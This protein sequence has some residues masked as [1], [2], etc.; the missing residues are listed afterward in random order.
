MSIYYKYTSDG[1]KLVVLSDV[2][3]S[4]YWYKSEELGKWF[5]D[6]LVKIPYEIPRI[7]T[8]VYVY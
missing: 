7:Y 6:T 2:D 4:V 1:S 8:L 3:D 5:L